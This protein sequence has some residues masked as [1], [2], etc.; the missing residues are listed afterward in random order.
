MNIKTPEIQLLE[1]LRPGEYESGK[2]KILEC[3]LE[4]LEVDFQGKFEI[5]PLTLN[6]ITWG[7]QTSGTPK[8]EF[9]SINYC[10]MHVYDV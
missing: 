8:K 1:V 3:T 10:Y 4:G 6:L 2:L 9:V 5:Y 7:F